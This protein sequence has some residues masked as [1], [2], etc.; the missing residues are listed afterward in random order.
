MYIGCAENIKDVTKALN[1]ATKIFRFNE[2]F[3]I[4]LSTKKFLMLQKVDPVLSNVIVIKN[5]S[6]N[7]IGACFL[8]DRLFYRGKFKLRGTFLSSI[9]IDEQYRRQG[10]SKLLIESAIKAIEK[11]ES[12]FAVLIA[13]RAADHFYNKFGFWGISHYNKIHLNVSKPILNKNNGSFSLA[14]KKDLSAIN[15]IYDSTYS[16]LYGSCCRSESDWIFLFGKVKSQNY[17]IVIYKISGKISGYIIFSKFEVVEFAS[18]RKVSCFEML[19]SY[20]RKFSLDKLIVSCSHKHPILEDMKDIDI[21]F[22]SRQCSYGGHMVRVINS[23]ALLRIFTAEYRAKLNYFG[24][25]KYHEIRKGSEIKFSKEKLE[26]NFTDSLFTHENTTLLMGAELLS[27]NKIE[28]SI[29]GSEPF[30]ILLFDQI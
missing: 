29:L 7:L 10:L 1:L 25:G 22:T 6:G 28:L 26:I 8:I 11:R 21:T 4:A 18:T 15:K 20:F 19:T 14:S 27:R 24:I 9:C 2:D 13:R 23:K 16:K 5:N 12:D 3:D 30:N 17:K